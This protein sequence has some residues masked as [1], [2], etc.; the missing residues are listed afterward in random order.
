MLKAQDLVC[1]LVA[2]LV[3]Q[4]W[5]YA[6]LSAFTELSISQSH[7]SCKRLRDA[8]LLRQDPGEAWLVSAPKLTE[9]LA[10]G[11]PYVFPGRVGEPT[12]GIPT[13]YTADFVAKAFVADQAT[14]VVWPT[15]DGE[16]KG[17][18]LDP[19]H[20]CQ[21]RCIAK[22]GG[23]PVYRA[24]VCVDLLRIG[25]SRERAWA[26]DYLLDLLKHAGG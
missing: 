26:K 19:L 6:S 20:P 13:A 14:P 25:Q 15:L 23:E 9:F 16:T 2:R 1:A 17:S 22:P 24:L 21:L 7:I 10:H 12:R 8:G 5:S 11:V 4:A 3:P 18:A